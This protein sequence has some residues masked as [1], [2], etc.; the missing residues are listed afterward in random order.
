MPKSTKPTL[1]LIRAE[2]ASSAPPPPA[3]LDETGAHLWR[4]VTAVYEFDDPGSYEVLAQACAARSRAARCAAQIDRD[5]EVIRS[6]RSV[7]SHPLLRDECSFRALTCRL[8]RH[9][10]LDLE[11]VRAGP[12][13]P[14]GVV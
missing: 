5:G 3:Y 4:E 7:R 9:L 6:G 14:P 1:S 8:L 10:G 2:P 11:P 13:R 12:G